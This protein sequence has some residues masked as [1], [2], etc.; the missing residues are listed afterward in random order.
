MT[1]DTHVREGADQRRIDLDQNDEI[2]Y[3]TKRWGVSRAELRMGV[4][5]AGP[6]ARHVAML[7]GKTL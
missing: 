4:Q 2:E 3:W 6:L 5:R 1:N 7:L